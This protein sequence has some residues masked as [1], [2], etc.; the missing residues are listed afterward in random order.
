MFQL[1]GVLILVRP[2]KAHAAFYR[3]GED[4]DPKVLTGLDRKSIRAR[5]FKIFRFAGNW[6]YQLGEILEDGSLIRSITNLPQT[7]RILN[8]DQQGRVHI[9]QGVYA[10]PPSSR[11]EPERILKLWRLGPVEAYLVRLVGDH[12]PFA[13][14]QFSSGTTVL[15]RPVV[16][17]NLFFSTQDG[18]VAKLAQMTKDQLRI[19]GFQ[20]L[21]HIG[22]WEER[23]EE[24]V[25]HGRPLTYFD[26]G[27]WVRR[28]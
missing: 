24:V 4:L 27:K 11:I 7:A 15:I 10:G 8:V 22:R 17:S 28:E 12:I 9:A 3:R 2:V 5:G 14:F 6:R 19:T 13:V 25:L 20:S 18:D 26:H 23:L 1:P 21:P 16:P